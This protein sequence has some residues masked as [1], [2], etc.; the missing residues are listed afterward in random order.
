MCPSLGKPKSRGT[1][2]LHSKNPLQYPKIDPCY[3]SDEKVS[4]LVITLNVHLI[5]MIVFEYQPEV[6]FYYNL[7]LT[8]E[9]LVLSMQT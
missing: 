1:I 9:L 3:L 8:K 2:R 7:F 6:R 5:Y 4:P